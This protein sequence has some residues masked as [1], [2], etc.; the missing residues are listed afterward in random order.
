MDKK[1]HMV[2]VSPGKRASK[3][4]RKLRADFLNIQFV[5]LDSWLTVSAAAN[6]GQNSVHER[7]HSISF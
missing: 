2:N 1:Q 7:E 4:W 3:M 5:L 6:A